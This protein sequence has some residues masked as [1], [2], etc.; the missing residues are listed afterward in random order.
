MM[1]PP[2]ALLTQLAISSCQEGILHRVL[3]KKG[4]DSM[5]WVL[6][7]ATGTLDGVTY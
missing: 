4:F 7:T 5:N 3:E 2:D 1:V 6:D